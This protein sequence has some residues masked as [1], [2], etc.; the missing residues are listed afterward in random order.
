MNAGGILGSM[1]F[2]SFPGFAGRLFATEDAEFRWRWLQAYNDWHVEEWCA[3]LSGAVH[4][5]CVCR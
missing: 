5:R 4:S 1:C 3:G 2:P